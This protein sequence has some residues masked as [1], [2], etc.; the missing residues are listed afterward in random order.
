[1]LGSVRSPS[2]FGNRG[3]WACLPAPA[4]VTLRIP[5][6]LS[7]RQP[8]ERAAE[9]PVFRQELGRTAP[10]SGPGVGAIER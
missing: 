3:L 9:M 2:V 8:S 1:M 7:G 4:S 10:R 6:G 5:L